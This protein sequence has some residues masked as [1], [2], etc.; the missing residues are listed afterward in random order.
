MNDESS[1]EYDGY[2]V[3]NKIIQL[4]GSDD[5]GLVDGLP[6]YDE[7]SPGEGFEEVNLTGKNIENSF[8]TE[9]TEISEV[10]L[11]RYIYEDLNTAEAYVDGSLQTV[12]IPNKKTADVF[13]VNDRVF[14]R[15]GKQE[16]HELESTLLSLSSSRQF[17]TIE[18]ESDFF[19]WLLYRDFADNSIDE[20]I[21]ISNLSD[22]KV[23]GKKDSL[24][25]FNSVSGSTN[26]LESAAIVA[27]ILSG[28]HLEMLGGDFTL[29]D[30]YNLRVS[31]S[32]QRVHI[33]AA[34]DIRNLPDIERILVSLKFL[35]EFCDLYNRWL[36]LDSED[37][38]PPNDFFNKLVEFLEER[39]VNI[40][41]P[42]YRTIS[43]YEIKRG[44]HS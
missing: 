27:G 15:G 10:E 43:E 41:Y 35:N 4:E 19:L 6:Q 30:S 40:N 33:K 39:E 22:A 18:F 21:Q 2:L 28:N 17:T 32:N 1:F 26:V 12:H 20:D 3:F 31:I 37:K 34:D 38:Y 25:K 7:K 29:L 44:D 8:L 24:G 5:A 16:I 14:I 13:K 42:V 11:Y 9:S 36:A 23:S